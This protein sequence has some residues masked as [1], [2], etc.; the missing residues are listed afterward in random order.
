MATQHPLYQLTE[1]LVPAIPT[2]LASGYALI[3]TDIFKG[4]EIISTS[5]VASEIASEVERLNREHHDSN[6]SYWLGLIDEGRIY[7]AIYGEVVSPYH[8]IDLRAQAWIDCLVLD[9]FEIPREKCPQ[10]VRHCT[11]PVDVA[12]H[13][14]ANADSLYSENT[15]IYTPTIDEEMESVTIR[16]IELGHRTLKGISAETL[17]DVVGSY[18]RQVA[19][20]ELAHV[21]IAGI[22]AEGMHL[23]IEIEDIGS[24]EGD[25]LIRWWRGDLDEHFEVNYRALM[26]VGQ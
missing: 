13:L 12:H 21:Q 7:S 4:G 5:E 1:G 2:D 26:E 17:G 16:C 8:R 10:I 25:H 20:G 15:L 19:S 23:W 18:R 22:S 14:A 11:I 3:R 24:D 9:P 6:D